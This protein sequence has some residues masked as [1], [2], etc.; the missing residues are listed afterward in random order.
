MTFISAHEKK[1][2]R[3]IRKIQQKFIATKGEGGEEELEEEGWE[4]DEA[5]EEEQESEIDQD[6]GEEEGD[7]ENEETKEEEEASEEEEGEVFIDRR[8]E[9]FRTD[10]LS[11]Y[12][13]N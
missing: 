5:V 10:G 13:L 7:D 4:T 2:K 11:F 8:V 1:A 6:D 9:G 12:K 3:K